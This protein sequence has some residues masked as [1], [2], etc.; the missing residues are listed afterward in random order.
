MRG[1][2]SSDLGQY[3]ISDIRSLKEVATDQVL[4]GLAPETYH[5][6][7]GYI[8]ALNEVLALSGELYEAETNAKGKT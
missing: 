3:L 6:K 7:L 2:V 8:T 1:F 5:N 4:A